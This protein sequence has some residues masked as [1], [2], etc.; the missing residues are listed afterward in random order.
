MTSARTA[1]RV[2]IIDVA[3]EANV[4]FAT[5][6]RVVTGKGYV[7][8][9]TRERVVDAMART[10]YVVN[11]EARALAGGRHQVIGLLVPDLD[12]SY[13]WEILRG[14]DEELAAASYDLMLYTTHRRM[15]RES[16][17]VHSLTQGST[18]GLLMILPMDP[19]SYVDSI[20][21]RDFPYVI[22]DHTGVDEQGPSVGAT[23][24]QGAINA[25]DYLLSLG[26]RR[27]GFI[28]GI[29]EMGCAQERLVGYQ[30]AL[31]TAGLPF[32]ASLV[33]EGDFRQPRAYECTRR[34]LALPDP[35]TAIFAANDISAY[36]V[37]DAARDAGLRI[38]DHISVVGFDDI[39]SSAHTNPPLTTIRQPMREMGRLAARMLFALIDDP[40]RGVERIALP[41]ELVI[42]STC[43][44]LV[45]Q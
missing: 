18:D 33:E 22:I 31:L 37:M 38:P 42:R 21:R 27:I 14:I 9:A 8:P 10:G 13:G 16:E 4:S 24:R 12:T 41:T 15:T 35:P 6:S 28:T 1:E 32:D 25:V 39:P 5:V 7:S 43:R 30:T 11:R 19:G 2:T 40:K 29:A 20:R 26:H 34:L 3:K 45:E 17:F 36:G 44:P 23:N